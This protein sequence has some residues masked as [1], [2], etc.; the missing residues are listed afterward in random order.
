MKQ[1]T[2]AQHWARKRN[3]HRL[4]VMGAISLCNN[5]ILTD[6]ER[7]KLAKVVGILGTVLGNW[8]MSNRVSKKNYLERRCNKQ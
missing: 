7:H 2:D 3:W 5:E 6:D 1:T 4:R 8:E